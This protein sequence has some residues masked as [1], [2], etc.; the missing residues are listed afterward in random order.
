MFFDSALFYPRIYNHLSI[1]VKNGFFLSNFNSYGFNPVSVPMDTP[2]LIA[3]P[4]FYVRNYS[5]YSGK[6]AFI[7]VLIISPEIQVF[8]I[9]I[10]SFCLYPATHVLFTTI[11]ICSQK[12]SSAETCLDEFYYQASNPDAMGFLVSTRKKCSHKRKM[13]P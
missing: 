3:A 7:R 11:N 8:T 5:I 6:V 10:R 1:D 2:N 9:M 12:E 13:Q 4:F